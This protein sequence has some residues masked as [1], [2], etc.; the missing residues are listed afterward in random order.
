[1]DKQTETQ[2]KA[3]KVILFTYEGRDKSGS[4]VKGELNGVNAQWV[5]AELRSLGITP[6]KVRRKSTPFFKLG[7]RRIKGGDIAL[8]TRQLATMLSAGI[9]LMQSIDIVARGSDSPKLA[10]L[11][12]SIKVDVEGGTALS[13][14]LKKFP[15]YFDELYCYLV[16]AG[17][18]SGTLDTMLDRIANYLEKT[19]S[20][21]R[22][23][24]RALFYPVA[25]VFV[26]IGVTSILLVFVVPQFRDLFKQFNAD[27][28]AFTLFVLHLSELFTSYGIYLLGL[29]IIAVFAFLRAKRQSVKFSHALDRL[30]LKMP[31][32]GNLQ[33]KAVIARYARTLSTTFAAGVPLVE[34]LTSVAHATGN[35]VFKDAVLTIRDKVATGAQMHVAMRDTGLFPPMVLQMV[36]I[37]EESGALDKMLGKVAVIFEE[38]V[39]TSVE[40]LSSLL[41]PFIIV[42]LGVL[43]GGLV[44]A[45]YLPIFKLGSVI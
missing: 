40:G 11:M 28:P 43:I 5:R 32:F 31:L 9:P 8:L 17:E 10:A 30:S 4:M 23:I 35:V 1:M 33:R 39:D 15:R 37:G 22:K 26:A 29:V 2:K 19:E 38:E 42:L 16:E 36:S 34:S 6:I 18:A 44:V 13:E 3:S 45:M 21:K 20:L 27:L 14:C 25:V 7:Q 24:K 41:E 12:T